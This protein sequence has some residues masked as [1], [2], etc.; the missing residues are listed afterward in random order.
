M[1]IFSKMNTPSASSM[2]ND[3]VSLGVHLQLFFLFPC[4]IPLYPFVSF[5]ITWYKIKA[6]ICLLATHDQNTLV[7]VV[8]WFR[9]AQS[10]IIYTECQELPQITL[11]WKPQSCHTFKY[12]QQNFFFNAAIQCLLVNKGLIQACLKITILKKIS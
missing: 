6:F 2:G 12:Q 7:Q 1:L 3:S 8:Q 5:N 9:M 11:F 4:S 10:N